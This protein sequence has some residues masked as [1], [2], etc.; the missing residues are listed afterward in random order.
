M[1]TKYCLTYFIFCISCPF[2]ALCQTDKF[3]QRTIAF[4]N[5]EN[6]FDTIDDP[7]TIDEAYTP[8]GENHYS[9]KDY[10]A[11]IKNTAKVISS[12]G[13]HGKNSGP[14]IIGLAEIENMQV[15]IDLVSTKE[16]NKKQYQIIHHDSPDRRG[17]DVAFLYREKFFSPIQHETIELKLRN[18]KAERIYT[19]DILYVEGILDNQMIHVFVNH[20]PSRR[21]GKT[22]SDP[23]RMKAAYLVKK[24][25]DQILMQDHDALIFILGDFNDDPIDKSIKIGLLFPS[26]IENEMSNT[27]FNPMERMFH[28]GF[29]TL[30]YRDGL[31]LFDQI[32]LSKSLLKSDYNQSGFVFYKAG[33]Y[34][35]VYLISQHGKYKGYPLRSFVNNRF[36][37]GYSDHFPVYVKLIKP[38]APGTIP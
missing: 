10:V 20:W 14:V 1:L 29:N 35:P 2:I 21:G 19:R 37:G 34:N 32:I 23:K 4:Y 17:I 7:E 22:R 13:F 38:H 5:V 33:V 25:I 24:K 16:L 3:I 28:K 31:N 15:L 9:Q 11:K 18:E 27:L 8:Q 30:A 36:S 6:L 26:E 12:I